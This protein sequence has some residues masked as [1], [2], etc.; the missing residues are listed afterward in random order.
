MY[1]YIFKVLA[2]QNISRIIITISIFKT[3]CLLALYWALACLKEMYNTSSS[4]DL[5]CLSF[6]SCLY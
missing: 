1:T 4:D 6:N 2:L 5:K 3:I